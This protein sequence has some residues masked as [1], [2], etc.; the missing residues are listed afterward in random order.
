V[1]LHC[2]HDALSGPLRSALVKSLE[3]IVA[4]YAN[5]I[6]TSMPNNTPDI[7]NETQMQDDV[8][9]PS[10]L[11]L[12]LR[13]SADANTPLR[14]SVDAN[15]AMT[16]A[17]Q[18]IHTLMRLAPQHYDEPFR[19][20]GIAVNIARISGM[21]HT[22]TNVS[23]TNANAASSSSA[24]ETEQEPLIQ[25][26]SHGTY[27]Q[28][29][30]L[31]LVDRFFGG[32]AHAQRLTPAGTSVCA[33]LAAIR[34][35]LV[36]SES[37]A[38]DD[39][40]M[41]D[42]SASLSQNHY[43]LRA[44]EDLSAVLRSQASIYPE[45]LIDSGVPA[46]LLEAM[47]QSPREAREA[48]LT[49]FAN[50]TEA[51]ETL[52]SVM[53][54][55]VDK[56]PSEAAK[57]LPWLLPCASSAPAYGTGLLYLSDGSNSGT[58]ILKQWITVRLQR[59]P[60]CT[61]LPDISGTEIRIE[62]LAFT[63]SL[64]TNVT[65]LLNKASQQHSSSGHRSHHDRDERHHELRAMM[66]AFGDDPDGTPL[67]LLEHIRQFMDHDQRGSDNMQMVTRSFSA[68]P[69]VHQWDRET[70]G[71]TGAAKR[72]LVLPNMP[73]N[74]AAS[75]SGTSAARTSNTGA[76]ASSS[77]SSAVRMMGAIGVDMG[78]ES[79]GAAGLP[80][81]FSDGRSARMARRLAGSQSARTHGYSTRSGD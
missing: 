21:T 72:A 27:Q 44:C 41:V 12:P 49:V 17:L 6:A 45:E 75:G 39:V 65:E 63:H 29:Y 81:S 61:D 38:E 51:R 53:R 54:Q 23:Q 32:H 77:G 66:Q 28:D 60:Q 69:S 68:L 20:S 10:S 42:A 8:D 24:A 31:Y 30:A 40:M 76:G 26:D 71:V 55:S 56:V 9:V 25:M 7:R 46:A 5:V 16:S 78:S 15:T 36:L 4:A 74:A 62:P 43:I 37:Q 22:A 67:S 18:C 57:L 34:D 59:A 14:L 11:P 1:L 35:L 3:V 2:S 70:S 58:S 33:Q 50:D 47:Q 79:A 52:I 13:P 64:R 73:G 19:R 48:I 80:T